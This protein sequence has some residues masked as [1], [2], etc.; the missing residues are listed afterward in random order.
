MKTCSL[1]SSRAFQ[2]LSRSLILLLTLG[3]GGAGVFEASGQCTAP[4]ANMVGW[5]P[6]DGNTNDIQGANHGT[7]Q[8]SATF[9]PGKVG[10]AF[11]LNPSASTGTGSDFVTFGNPTA[12]KITGSLTV[13]AWI[14]TNDFPQGALIEIVT[15]WGQNFTCGN[16]NTDSFILGLNKPG[17]T[18]QL[19]GIIHT[20]NGS[21]PALA[22]GSITPGQ[23]THVAMTYD[24]A[25]GAF[26]IYVNGSV[27]NSTTVAAGGICTSD[28][29]VM[30]GSED[31]FQGPSRRFSGLVD[32]VTISNRALSASEIQGIF[33][34]GAAGKCNG[35]NPSPTPAAVREVQNIST[36]VVVGTG[37]N[38]A[39]GGFII[40]GSG[41]K[42][43]IV[44][45][46]GPSLANFGVAGAMEDPSLELF[47]GSGNAI[48]FNDDWLSGGQTQ[49]IA[50]LLPPG[51]GVE[52]AIIASLTPGNYT[53]VLR[54]YNNA[55]GIALVEV[56]DL[57]QGA[58]SRLANISTRG[59]VGT[60]G[61]V[62]IGGFIVGK[63]AQ[64]VVRAI[65]PSL[66]AVGIATALSNPV[67][68]L[69]N[70]QGAKLDTNDN[71]QGHPSSS[72]VSS[73]GLAPT[74]ALESA[75]IR[76]LAPGNYTAI[77]RG[78]NDGI[79][80][81]LVEVYNTTSSP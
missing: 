30:I 22:G 2:Q 61:S 41:S 40:L 46:I 51:D 27:V 79:G 33:N 64:F 66:A 15:K 77:V 43:V 3:A 16:S 34:A 44:R 76:T 24:A 36:R 6:G 42:R 47:N 69:Y 10:Q 54:G 38:V 58:P 63:Q 49:E 17:A 45:A 23:F 18:I 8:G 56:Y 20:S 31:S 19:V 9:A 71:W 59:H 48:A 39:I 4:P 72:Q 5:W 1:P 7:L 35:P 21:E 12:L 13:D 75:L 11:S 50:A 81:G 70:G 32:E 53:A 55:T 25:T 29:N 73:L 78:F 37:E 60:G 57:N 28:K 68:E 62:L 65:G 26:A 67:L 52:A 14:K 74:N 80:V